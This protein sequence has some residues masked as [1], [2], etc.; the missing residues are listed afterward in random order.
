MRGRDTKGVRNGTKVVGGGAL[1]GPRQEQTEL[2]KKKREL[3]NPR[4][5]AARGAGVSGGVCMEKGARWRRNAP[6]GGP[7]KGQS[8]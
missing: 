1:G 6:R 3:F 7:R 2:T 8:K 4:R 5:S